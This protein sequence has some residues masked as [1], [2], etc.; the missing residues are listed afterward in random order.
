MNRLEKAKLRNMALKPKIPIRCIVSKKKNENTD[1]K[2]SDTKILNNERPD[3]LADIPITI[4]QNNSEQLDDKI[5]DKIYT[6]EDGTTYTYRLGKRKTI[7]RNGEVT[8][9]MY[10]IKTVVKQ[11]KEKR[12][13]KSLPNKKKLRGMIKDLSD[14]NCEKII[15]YY[16]EYIKP[17]EPSIDEAAET[18]ADSIIDDESDEN[19]ESE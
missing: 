9:R 8:E 13:P 5:I 3:N 18:L 14:N 15:K 10:K 4:K 19:I 16:E 2:I 12:G 11:V 1:N 17:K 7:K 6:A